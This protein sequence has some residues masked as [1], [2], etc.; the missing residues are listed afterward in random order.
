MRVKGK[1]IGDLAA[2]AAVFV[3]D[4]MLEPEG[5]DVGE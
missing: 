3:V 2:K 5:Q 1:V 4:G